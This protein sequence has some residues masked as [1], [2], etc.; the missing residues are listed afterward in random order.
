MARGQSASGTSI[1]VYV[2]GVL[3]IRYGDATRDITLALV[4]I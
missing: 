4:S 3:Q 1:T 2:N